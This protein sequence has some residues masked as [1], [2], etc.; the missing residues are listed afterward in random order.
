MTPGFSR[1]ARA[2]STESSTAAR[3][4]PSTPATSTRGTPRKTNSS[5]SAAGS[6]TAAVAPA[7]A[8]HSPSVPPTRLHSAPPATTPAPSARA[9]VG[10]ATRRPTTNPRA[11]APAG[12][13]R[14]PTGVKPAA[15]MPIS[16][17]IAPKA[18][19]MASA[20][21][22]AV[23]RRSSP[24]ARTAVRAA[25]TTTERTTP[26]AR[27]AIDHPI[28]FRGARGVVAP[29]AVNAP[30]D[31]GAPAAASPPPPARS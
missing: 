25:K 9:A 19:S 23:T 11:P 21:T 30:R 22:R 7:T 14:R 13:H 2:N 5:A 16:Q 28:A 6:S 15:R 10:A 8:R 1:W 31:A 18:A 27:K 20:W 4:R 24:G 29:A 26:D 3:H 12:T 17:V